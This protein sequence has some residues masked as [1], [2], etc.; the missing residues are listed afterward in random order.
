MVREIFVISCNALDIVIKV[1]MS[2]ISQ[3]PED[4]G[5][6]EETLRGF[7]ARGVT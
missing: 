7:L 1:W 3:A 5:D 4:A 2:S 6:T